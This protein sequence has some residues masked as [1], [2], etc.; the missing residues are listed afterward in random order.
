MNSPLKPLGPNLTIEQD[1]TGAIQLERNVWKSN[2]KRTNHINVRYFYITDRFKK[3]N[4]SRIISKPTGDMESDY[5]TKALKGKV[6]HA[7]R[8]TLLGLDGINELMFYKKYKNQ[9]G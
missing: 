7:H 3:G 4:M 8:K 9:S 5:L 1:N 2:R 6:F